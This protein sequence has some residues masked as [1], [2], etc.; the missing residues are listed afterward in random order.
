[1]A[2]NDP[3]D[4]EPRGK[5]QTH[6][7]LKPHWGLGMPKI[8]NVEEW[9]KQ[10]REREERIQERFSRGV[11]LFRHDK[12]REGAQDIFDAIGLMLGY[13]RDYSETHQQVIERLDRI[14]AALAKLPPEEDAQS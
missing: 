14:E 12:G 8:V 9:M 2:I 3:P 13:Y 5:I 4:W 7:G 11:N 1:M 10:K 6:P